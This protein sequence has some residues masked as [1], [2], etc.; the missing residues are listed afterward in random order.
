ML[1]TSPEL[2]FRSSGVKKLIG[3]G[4]RDSIA[5]NVRARD[6][7]RLEDVLVDGSPVKKRPRD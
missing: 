1:T 6:S 2:V 3:Q 4:T 7:P 5:S